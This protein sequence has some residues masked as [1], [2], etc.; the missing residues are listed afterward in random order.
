MGIH[1]GVVAVAWSATCN[2]RPYVLYG[3]AARL[4]APE[5]EDE[6]TKNKGGGHANVST[7]QTAN[8]QTELRALSVCVCVLSVFVRCGSWGVF[9]TQTGAQFIVNSHQVG[10]ITALAAALPF[11]CFSLRK[12]SPSYLREIP[13]FAF[14]PN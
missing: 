11:G 8:S 2:P 4:S 9:R 7:K 12:L 6:D 1:C 14:L 5:N 10:V 3:S 13:F